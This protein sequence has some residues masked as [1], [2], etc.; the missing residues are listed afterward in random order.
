MDCSAVRFSGHALRRM[1]ERGLTRTDVLAVITTGAVIANYPEDRP[2]PSSLL[3]G[4][5]Q[6]RA[7]HVVV[8]RDED[9]G[10]CYVVTAYPPDPNLWQDDFR[11]RR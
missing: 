6:G 2:Y 7:I 5:P 10:E 11:S 9:R 8:A 3:L 4:F 1:F